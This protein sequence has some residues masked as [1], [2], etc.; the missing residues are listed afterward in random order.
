MHWTLKSWNLKHVIW[1][2]V[3]TIIVTRGL[4]YDVVP[5]PCD[6]WPYIVGQLEGSMK[7]SRIQCH[8]SIS[9]LGAGTK[10]PDIHNFRIPI[11]CHE[12]LRFDPRGPANLIINNQIR[13]SRLNPKSL[14]LWTGWWILKFLT[15]F[16]KLYCIIGLYQN[17]NI[18]WRVDRSCYCLMVNSQGKEVIFCLLT[19]PDDRSLACDDWRLI[20]LGHFEFNSLQ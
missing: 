2:N 17:Q 15:N 1:L 9:G 12:V 6:F 10:I 3:K 5:A 16:R 7:I 19:V 18:W 11:P 4:T 14:I 20:H 8:L 13:G